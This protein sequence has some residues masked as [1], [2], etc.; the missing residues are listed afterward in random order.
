[1][2]LAVGNGLGLGLR[3]EADELAVLCSSPG[4]RQ[5]IRDCSGAS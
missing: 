2:P 1:V 5:S 4:F 3:L